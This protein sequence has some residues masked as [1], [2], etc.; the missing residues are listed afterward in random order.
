MK[1]APSLITVNLMLIRDCLSRKTIF[2]SGNDNFI[3]QVNSLIDSTKSLVNSVNIEI[4]SD[5]DC[6][7]EDWL[8]M[9]K[10]TYILLDVYQTELNDFERD[11]KAHYLG[12]EKDYKS[13]YR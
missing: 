2:Y 1:I 9:Q 8:T 11:W 5:S 4:A 7:V 10:A 3:S 6:P 13:G 12:R